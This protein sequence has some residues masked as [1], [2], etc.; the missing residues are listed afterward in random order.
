[1]AGSRELPCSN[2]GAPL[3]YDPGALSLA[4][5]HCG[6]VNELPPEPEGPWGKAGEVRELDYASALA[7]ESE[8]VG[9]EDAATIRCPGCGAEISFGPDTVADLCPFC[10]TPLA[11]ADSHPHRHP[12]PQAVLPFAI[13]E[14]EARERMGHWLRGLWFAPPGLKEYARAGRPMVGVYLPHYTYDARGSAEYQGMRGDAYHVTQMV[15]VSRNGKTRMV[16]RQVRKVRWRPVSGR[17]E[18]AFDEILVAASETLSPGGGA[19]QDGNRIWD[20]AGLESYRTEFLAGF[21]AEAPTLA[22]D[23]GFA[24][25]REAMEAALRDDVRADIGGDE[26]RIARMR[27]SYRAI[28]FKHVLLPVWLAAYRFRGQPYRV[29]VNARTGAVSG[30][31]PWSAAKILVAILAGLLL[32]AGLAWLMAQGQ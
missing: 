10:A 28:T 29:V 13:P 23:Q 20:L 11:K 14:R 5:A 9:F 12:R 22:L 19:A 4:C 27:S 18:H 3:A 21:R 24:R 32:L 17:V 15:P 16:Q 26:Q 1:M 6:T 31:R 2:C 8:D 30:E 7:R 25:A